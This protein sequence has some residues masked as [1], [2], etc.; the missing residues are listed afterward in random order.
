MMEKKKN[1]RTES[2][3]RKLKKKTATGHT[4]IAPM[5]S[6]GRCKSLGDTATCASSTNNIEK[7]SRESVFR[8]C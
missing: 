1:G 6:P 3:Y 7:L 2:V 4:R 5:G 8:S